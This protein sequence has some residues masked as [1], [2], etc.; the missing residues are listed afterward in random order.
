MKEG[1]ADFVGNGAVRARAD[2][3][4]KVAVFADD[5]DELMDEEIGSLE[6]I[7]FDVSPGNIADGGVGLPVLGLDAFTETAFEIAGARVPIE[8]ELLDVDDAGDFVLSIEIIVEGGELCDVGTVVGL[9]SPP[10]EVHDLGFVLLNDFGGASEPVIGEFGADEGPIV[11]E[12]IGLVLQPMVSWAVER[13]KL[14]IVDIGTECAAAIEEEI[15]LGAM[16]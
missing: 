8:S 13:S 11:H 6:L 1:G 3:E 4:E 14:G 7:V 10:V 15:V 12:D 9:P 16:E 5:V 2:V